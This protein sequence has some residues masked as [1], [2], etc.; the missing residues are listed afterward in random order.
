MRVTEREMIV[1][2][3]ENSLCIDT[4]EIVK[5]KNDII[6]KPRDVKSVSTS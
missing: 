6:N 3:G 2:S 1:R 4:G 5:K